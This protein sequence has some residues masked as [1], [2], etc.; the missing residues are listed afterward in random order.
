MRNGFGEV[1]QQIDWPR[2]WLARF[3]PEEDETRTIWE[4]IRITCEELGPT[5]VKIAQ[6]LSTR[7]DLI[8][9]P[10]VEEFTKLRNQV[11]P[12][13]FE[14][15]RPVLDQ[16]L[17]HPPEHYFKDLQTEPVACASI[18]QVY[19]ARLKETNQWVAIKIQKPGIDKAIRSDLE[20]LAWFADKLHSNVEELKP[21]DLPA[22]VE[23]AK[24]SMA[25]ELDFQIEARNT[26]Y[27]NASNPHPDQ[28]FAP[29]VHDQFTSKRLLVTDWVEGLHPGQIK[30]S[31]EEGQQLAKNGGR[32]IFH[33]VIMS[34]FFHADP[35]GGNI[36]ITPDRKICF[37]DWGLSGQLTREMRYYLA[38]LLA[39]V[40][41]GDPER[42]VNVT[43]AQA[44]TAKRVERIALE[45][46]ISF[47]LRKYM[48][49]NTQSEAFGKLMIDLLQVYSRHGIQL[50]RDYAMLA[51]A[52]NNIE[53]AAAQMDPDFDVR[54]IAEPFLKQLAWERR[55]PV[56]MARKSW[57]S[58]ITNLRHLRELPSEIQRILRNIETGDIR[59]KMK[60]EGADELARA[61]H[62]AS[63]HLTLGIIIGALIIGCSMIITTDVHPHLFGY[64][65]IGMIGFLFSACLGLWLVWDIIRSG[66][67][68]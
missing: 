1:I 5:F 42:V 50:A 11:K 41:S 63:N 62:D 45:K 52:V 32:S 61:F 10:L 16:A 27:F 29:L 51:K 49:F 54:L 13:D 59:I 68:K 66:R 17:K 58:L 67:R 14:T 44:I 3:T 48:R 28:V 53:E 57:W 31:P 34:G 38:D 26:N 64:P 33:Q 23:E 20:I 36:L 56:N 37:V 24:R 12:L 15:L 46:E 35:H 55:N 4:R 6:I 22:L 9:P 30:L 60:H 65:A 2:R 8:P 39:A 40:S 18:A 21:F 43:L 47:V 7:P 19:R 25:Q